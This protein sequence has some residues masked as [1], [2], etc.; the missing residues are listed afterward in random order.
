MC[1]GGTAL[2][3]HAVGH[4]RSRNT[5]HT[6]AIS[7][8][9]SGAR[10]C[11]EDDNNEDKGQHPS[12]ASS[13]CI[14]VNGSRPSPAKGRRFRVPASPGIAASGT[15]R[16]LPG[17][18]ATAPSCHGLA[19]SIFDGVTFPLCLHGLSS[20]ALLHHAH[21]GPTY[22]CFQ[23]PSPRGNMQRTVVLFPVLKR[24]YEVVLSFFRGILL[25]SHFFSI[26]GSVIAR[27]SMAW[28]NCSPRSRMVD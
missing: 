18:S 23:C 12:A 7:H 1:C 15:L 8:S 9:T 21:Q 14:I 6:A 22:W 4:V 27:A 13:R 24:V 10:T 2:P 19:W 11:H 28:S 16:F 25:L 5:P 26:P 17:T 20:F 3:P